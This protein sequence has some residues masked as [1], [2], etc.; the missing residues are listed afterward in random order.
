MARTSTRKPATEAQVAE[1]QAKLKAAHDE[2]EAGVA[3]LTNSA[4]W[5]A[6]LRTASRFHRYSLNNRLMIWLQN[7]GA[8]QVAGYNT[9]L[10]LGYQ[11]RKG[12]KGLR[13]FRPTKRR[14]TEDEAREAGRPELAGTYRVVGFALTSVFDISQ[15]DAIPGKAQSLEQPAPFALPEGDAPA[16]LVEG[17]A[18]QIRAL[19]F[20]VE[21]GDVD[22]VSPGAYGVTIYSERRVVISANASEAGKAEVLAHEL[23]H[24]SCGHEH[25]RD[26]ARSRREVE[27]ESVAYAVCAHEGLNTSCGSF[28][29]V[30]GWADNDKKAEAVREV[31][32]LVL[33]VAGEIVGRLHDAETVEE[34][35]AELV[36][37]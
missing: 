6:F 33:R 31:A 25:R 13:I 29:Y 26:D 12:A 5:A 24:I 22:E 7:P 21:Y 10:D 37:A 27:A 11:V 1:R 32:E 18:D 16:G 3:Q 14:I 28:G 36:A 20:S 8:T 35:D 19:G 2:L 4:E 23:G 34:Q 9:W 17:L 15:V 30:A